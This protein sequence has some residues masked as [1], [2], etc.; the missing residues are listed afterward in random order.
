M[1]LFVRIIMFGVS[2]SVVGFIMK[3]MWREE[4]R[5]C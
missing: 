1:C 5:G 2:I 3:V 4:D